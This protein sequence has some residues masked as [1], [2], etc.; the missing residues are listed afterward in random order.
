[1]RSDVAF[2]QRYRAAVQ[3]KIATRVRQHQAAVAALGAAPTAPL[4]MLAMAIA[5]S[6]TH[7]TAT[8]SHCP[9][10]TS[11]RNYPAPRPSSP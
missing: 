11:S 10:Q 1:M 8:R 3:D 2:N 6:I 9:A 5:G 4:V 7:W